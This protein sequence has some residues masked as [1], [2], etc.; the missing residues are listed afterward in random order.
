M[1]SERIMQ[2]TVN[3]GR[4]RIELEAI[5]SRVIGGARPPDPGVADPPAAVRAALEAPFEYPALRRA[6]T[7]DDHVTVVVDERLP[8]LAYLLVPIL[9][10]LTRAGVAAHA[11]AILVPPSTTGQRWID[12]LPDEFQEARVEVHDPTNRKRLRYLATTRG[13]RRL[14][15]NQHVVDAD[16]VVVLSG[17]RYDPVTG[18]SGAEGAIF[19]DLADAETRTELG[20]NGRLIVPDDEPW[21][22]MKEAIETSWLLG[23]PFFVQIIE[24][25]GDGVAAVVAGTTEASV[26]GR[27]RLDSR[28]L[29][30]IPG[31]A[32][33]VVASVSGDPARHTFDDLAAAAACAAR[34][35]RPGGRIVLLSEV[36]AA[37]GPAFDLLR[38]VDDPGE[39]ASRL[40]PNPEVEQLPVA[41]WAIAADHARLT[42]LSKINPEAVEELSATPLQDA[43]QTQRFLDAGGTCLF[44]D[45]AHKALATLADD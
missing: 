3:F 36:A 9:E 35:V 10:H 20:S 22:A 29:Q 41:R 2:V 18:C 39:L 15:L 32:D 8:G 25:S 6:L 38:G 34:V 44:L 23:A 31:A 4:S 14:Y 24:G 43:G 5:S 45:D 28:W 27:S 11:V 17:R 13:G 37:P 26:E 21:P 33:V 40:G 42:V 7:P 19:P 16:Q 1:P 12:D 30:R